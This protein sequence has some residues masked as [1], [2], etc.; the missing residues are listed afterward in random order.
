VYI[1]LAVKAAEGRASVL[2]A[3]VLPDVTVPVL[4]I[5]GFSRK[6]MIPETPW[7]VAPATSSG[8]RFRWRPTTTDDVS[9]RKV[10]V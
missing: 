7:A 4:R 10:V 8:I 3:A 9:E 1:V 2:R 5:I 6:G